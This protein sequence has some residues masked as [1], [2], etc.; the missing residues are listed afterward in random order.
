[1]KV[2]LWFTT[3]ALCLLLP[4]LSGA[5][6]G[7]PAPRPMETDLLDDR[8]IE[9]PASQEAA[10]GPPDLEPTVI[11]ATST[12]GLRVAI[13]NRGGGAPDDVDPAGITILIERDGEPWRSL[14]LAEFDPGADLLTPGG[15]AER[16][17]DNDGWD[18]ATVLVF[19]DANQG[20]T[21][22]NEDNNSLSS[23]LFCPGRE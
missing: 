15:F 6:G 1:M 22:E 17:L 23:H 11:S 14:S 21:E 5:G 19:V 12:C 9:P 3:L 8:D 18:Q 2:L 16:V 4:A 10:P 13:K 20:L 7:D